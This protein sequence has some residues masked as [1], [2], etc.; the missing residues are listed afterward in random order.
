MKIDAALLSMMRS[1]GRNQAWAETM[2]N[3]EARKL[4]DVAN[5][6]ASFHLNNGLSRIQFA[7]EIKRSLKTSLRGAGWPAAMKTAWPASAGC[8]QKQAA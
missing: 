6:V 1:G 3:L 7:E 2:V 5:R 4:V 8:G